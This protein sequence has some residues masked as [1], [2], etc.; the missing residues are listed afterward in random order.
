MSAVS[1]IEDLAT[2]R[3]SFLIVQGVKARAIAVPTSIGWHIVV[4]WPDGCDASR[5]RLAVSCGVPGHARANPRSAR[6]D[7]PAVAVD[8]STL[9]ILRGDRS[10]CARP[11]RPER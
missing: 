1:E 3:A 10:D 4:R 5:S 2:A 7:G 8:Q 9:S 11:E 6:D